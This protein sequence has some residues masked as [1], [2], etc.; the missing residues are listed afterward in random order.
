MFCKPYKNW[1]ASIFQ[2]I[3]TGCVAFLSRGRFCEIYQPGLDACIF[4]RPQFFF[5]CFPPPWN[6]I[7][8]WKNFWRDISLRYFLLPLSLS[9]YFES[10]CIQRD[11]NLF[12]FPQPRCVWW[13]VT[14]LV[15]LPYAIAELISCCAGDGSIESSTTTK[16]QEACILVKCDVPVWIGNSL[17]QIQLGIIAN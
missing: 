3:P 1:Q 5:L 15:C 14:A 11:W 4:T 17:I 12:L 16:R 2:L 10:W 8:C 7:R 13:V 9:P 6:K